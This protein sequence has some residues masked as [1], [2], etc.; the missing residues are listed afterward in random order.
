VQFFSGKEIQ[1]R[2]AL[3]AHDVLAVPGG[4]VRISPKR[5]R[6]LAM[7]HGFGHEAVYR[8]IRA[9]SGEGPYW[10]GLEK[11]CRYAAKYVGK[12]ADQ[13]PSVPWR[14]EDGRLV[15]TGGR[16][17]SWTASCG[18]PA[19]MGEIAVRRAVEAEARRGPGRS[20][21]GEAGAGAAGSP[22]LLDVSTNCYTKEGQYT[23]CE[24][25]QLRKWAGVVDAI[26]SEVLARSV[27]PPGSIAE[28][29]PF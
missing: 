7:A 21:D 12:A 29:L 1:K 19:R 15:P 10:V 3:H 22:G 25:V 18:W 17:R 2:G 28:E 9:R 13:R 14:D 4:V 24:V 20:G 8:P 23:E 26:R 27:P 16:Y 6:E 11:A 5:L